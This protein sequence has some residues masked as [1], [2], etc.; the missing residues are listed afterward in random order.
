MMGLSCTHL[1]VAPHCLGTKYVTEND[2]KA[3]ISEVNPLEI[4]SCH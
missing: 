4:L 2:N 3:C 1:N